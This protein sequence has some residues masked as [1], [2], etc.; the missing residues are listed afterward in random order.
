LNNKSVLSGIYMLVVLSILT[1]CG[2]GGGGGGD[3]AT[4]APVAPTGVTATG[5]TAQTAI[6]WSAVTGATSYNLYWRSTTGVSKLNG[7]KITGVSSQYVHATLTNGTAYYYVVTAVNAGGES[8]DSVQVTATPQ[9]TATG[10]PTVVTATS[11]NA[12]ATIAWSAVTGAA[13]YN[14]YWSNTTGVTKTNGTKFAGVSSPYLHTSL[15]NGT[16]YYYV[17]T[18]VNAGGESVESAQVAATPTIPPPVTISNLRDKGV[19]QSGFVIGTASYAGLTAVQVSLNGGATWAAATGTT[20]WKFMLPAGINTWKDGSLHSIQVRAT[21]GTN[22]STPVIINLRKGINK[23][24]NGDGYADLAVGALS[25]TVGGTY[26]S[27]AA[28]VFHGSATGVASAAAS[29]AATTVTGTLGSYF[30]AAVALGDVNGDGYADLVVGAY[31]Y[32]TVVS[33]QTYTGAV[34]VF[35]GSNSGITSV[36]SSAANTTLLGNNRTGGSLFGSAV[37]LGDVNGDGYEDLAVGMVDVA[38]VFHGSSTGIASANYSAAASTVSGESNSSF[39]YSLAL[40][41]VNGDGYADLAVGAAKAYDKVYVF[42]GSTSGIADTS[43]STAS[44]VLTGPSGNSNFGISVALGDVNGDGYADLAVGADIALSNYGAAYVFHGSSA[45]VASVAAT[46]ANTTL[47]GNGRN[48][49]GAVVLGDVNGDGYADLAVGAYAKSAPNDG[50]AYVFHGTLTGV[51]NAATIAAMTTVTGP[52]SGYFGY[53]LSLSDVNGD[54][55][56]DLAVGAASAGSSGAA[57]VFHGAT[58]GV[59]G[60]AY[61]GAATTLSGVDSTSSFGGALGN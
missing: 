37:A 5:G 50:K 52:I 53:A 15:T 51:A 57:Y 7:T 23:D 10:A 45:G 34:Y 35:H 3:A 47:N 4:V 16:A 46:T 13:S 60:A 31:G 26:N 14:I 59:P 32:T 49:G 9:V 36:A 41:D 20:S 55:Y 43:F 33:T 61:T 22:F 29:A 54:G 44:T 21:D 17:V 42:N 40:G 30:G 56:S 58:L 25:A 39:G 12:Q 1:A 8:A 24:T 28:Y 11:G 38:Y 48:F 27:G 19:V 18:A 2:G 6:T